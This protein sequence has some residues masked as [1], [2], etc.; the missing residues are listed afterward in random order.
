MEKKF[1]HLL[2]MTHNEEE[3]IKKI[4]ILCGEELLSIS[5]KLW[6][7]VLEKGTKIDKN[8]NREK[9]TSRL[10]TSAS[11]QYQVGC[12][13]E[14]ESCKAKICMKTNPNCASNKIISTIKVLKDFVEEFEK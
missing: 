12:N 3:F 10:Q 8:F 13:Y 5:N 4:K 1:N 9:I 14:V 2:Q 7:Y 11:Y 6:N